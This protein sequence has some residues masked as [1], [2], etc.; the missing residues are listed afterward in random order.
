MGVGLPKIKANSAQCKVKLPTEAE[1]GNSFK[2]IFSSD[3]VLKKRF[4]T[5]VLVYVCLYPLLNMI[6]KMCYD[7]QKVHTLHMRRLQNAV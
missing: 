7:C 5:H 6:T 3:K 2:I 4:C 1:L